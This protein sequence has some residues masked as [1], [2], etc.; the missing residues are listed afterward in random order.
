[1]TL[2]QKLVEKLNEIAIE[3]DNQM[4]LG[5]TNGTDK[6]I[7]E[8]LIQVVYDHQNSLQFRTLHC[9]YSKSDG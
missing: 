3:H 7:A 1:M 8:Q 5:S 2:Y 4:V 9:C 6:L